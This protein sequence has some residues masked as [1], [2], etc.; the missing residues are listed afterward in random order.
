MDYDLSS[1][2]P[3]VNLIS[4]LTSTTPTNGTGRDFSLYQGKL[5]VS[6]A[7]GGSSETTG[8]LAVKLQDSTNN[9]AWADVSG[10]AFTNTTNAASI[11]QVSIDT[12]AVNRYLRAVATIG[13]SNTPS[14]GISVFANG[15]LKYN[16]NGVGSV[17]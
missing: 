3:Q 7:T 12:R 15:M 13:G 16:P 8:V 9:S 10:G 6:L 14:F 5:I 2:T 11:Q 4:T 1:L 17:T